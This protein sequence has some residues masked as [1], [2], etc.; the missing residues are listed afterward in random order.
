MLP[1]VAVERGVDGGWL[2]IHSPN[3]LGV[4]RAEGRQG[5]LGTEG[6]DLPARWACWR[7]VISHHNSVSGSEKSWFQ[8][9]VIKKHAAGPAN[10]A[11]LTELRYNYRNMITARRRKWDGQISR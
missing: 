11:A 8:H 2:T 6:P 7:P 10:R 9:D 1:G 4:Y 5:R 3:P